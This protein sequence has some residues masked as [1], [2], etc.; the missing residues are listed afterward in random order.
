MGLEK[1]S[2]AGV[3]R[4]EL[5]EDPSFTCLLPSGVL[6]SAD[7]CFASRTCCSESFASNESIE[8]GCMSS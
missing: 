5:V 2:D 4:V 3:R 8:L 7:F 1:D 6:E